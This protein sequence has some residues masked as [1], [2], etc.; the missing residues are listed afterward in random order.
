MAPRKTRASTGNRSAQS[1][2]S[3]GNTSKVTKPAA[4]TK[5]NKDKASPVVHLTKKVSAE[6]TPEPETLGHIS[7]TAAVQAQAKVE[8]S[9]RT[10]EEVE[11]ETVTAAQ[12]A[13]YWRAREGERL[14]ARVHQEDISMEERILR[15]WDVSSQY[16]VRL[17]FLLGDTYYAILKE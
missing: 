7:S 12:I 5:S 4:S 17:P 10:P 14:A 15:L 16:G 8:L 11:A 2:L 3:F 9:S 1:T 13:K 6:P